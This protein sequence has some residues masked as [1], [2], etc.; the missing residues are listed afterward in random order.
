MLPAGGSETSI[1]PSSGIG[2]WLPSLLSTGRQLV[3]ARESGEPPIAV[4]S[5]HA[6]GTFTALS[7]HARRTLALLAD[8]TIIGHLGD[9][10]E[11]VTTPFT[12]PSVTSLTLLTGLDVTAVVADQ[13]TRTLAAAIAGV[14]HQR[15]ERQRD[16]RA[17]HGRRLTRFERPAAA[18]NLANAIEIVVR[19]S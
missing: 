2:F 13:Q 3:W 6:A 17:R 16:L 4:S 1:N 12:S 19:S 5:D 9:A 15:D 7:A 8:G 10:V 11:T 14:V 18:G